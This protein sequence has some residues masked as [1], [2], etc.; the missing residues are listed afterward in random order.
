MP[1]TILLSTTSGADERYEI[2]GI[3]FGSYQFEYL[4]CR[5]RYRRILT[6][7]ARDYQTFTLNSTVSFSPTLFTNGGLTAPHPGGCAGVAVPLAK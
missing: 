1:V 6:P 3:N 4:P 7:A 2:N 5:Q